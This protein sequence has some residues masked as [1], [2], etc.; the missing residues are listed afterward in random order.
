[1][2]AACRESAHTQLRAAVVEL[3][4]KRFLGKINPVS[5]FAVIAAR[6]P[7]HREIRLHCVASATP[8]ELYGFR[9]QL[10]MGRANHRK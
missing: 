9:S 3:R 2:P 10:V 1:M 8:R 7:E 6:L 5:G 4:A